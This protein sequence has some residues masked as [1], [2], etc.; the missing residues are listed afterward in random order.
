MGLQ[1]QSQLRAWGTEDWTGLF[2]PYYQR[3]RNLAIISRK[4]APSANEGFL[5]VAFLIIKYNE[6]K[7]MSIASC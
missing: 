2:Q 3:K 7:Q 5:K 1:S 6:L 4:Y